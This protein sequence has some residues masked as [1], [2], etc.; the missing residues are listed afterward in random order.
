MRQHFTRLLVCAAM[1]GTASLA[2]VA[3]PGTTSGAATQLTVVC[4]SLT[5]TTTSETA[6]GC[7]GADVSQTGAKGTITPK[8]KGTGGTATIKWATGKTSTETFTYKTSSAASCPKKAGYTAVIEATQTSK[9]TAG[10][11][12][13]LIGSKSFVG[14][15]CEYS[16]SGKLYVFNV[17]NDT[18]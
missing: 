4:T 6:A 8:V 2:V 15:S 3:I 5:G 16:K 1:A 11:A 7:S 13:K 17:G 12:T 14:K 18:Y 10:T 9:V